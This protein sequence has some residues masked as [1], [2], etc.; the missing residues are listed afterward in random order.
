MRGQCSE[1]KLEHIINETEK[2]IPIRVLYF[3]PVVISLGFLEKIIVF[4]S[5]LMK[6]FPYQQS[7]QTAFYS[8][9]QDD[10]SHAFHGEVDHC[11]NLTNDGV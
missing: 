10:A 4:L 5:L 6:K 3:Y 1:F 11:T 8:N 7:D 9:A 2:L